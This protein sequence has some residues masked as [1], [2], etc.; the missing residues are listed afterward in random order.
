MALQYSLCLWCSAGSCMLQCFHIPVPNPI[1]MPLFSI[2]RA[3]RIPLHKLERQYHNLRYWKLIMCVHVCVCVCASMWVHVCVC[4]CVCAHVCV[5]VC[6]FMCVHVCVCVCA[7]MWVHVCVC[8]CGCMWVRTHNDLMKVVS[9]IIACTL[10][11]EMPCVGTSD[12]W[13][14]QTVWESLFWVF[15]MSPIL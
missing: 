10:A 9:F 11:G 12:R 4:V 6:G 2:P 3:S 8:V 14:L 5:C 15:L 1:F 7:S 13:W